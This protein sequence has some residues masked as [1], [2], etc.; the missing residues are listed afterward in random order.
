MTRRVTDRNYTERILS[1]PAPAALHRPPGQCG[2]EVSRTR[3]T[4]VTGQREVGAERSTVKNKGEWLR[5]KAVCGKADASVSLGWAGM[6]WG[7]SRDKDRDRNRSF[8]R[9]IKV[10]SRRGTEAKWSSRFWNN[11]FRL[12]GQAIQA[13]TGW[14]YLINGHLA[15]LPAGRASD[16]GAGVEPKPWLEARPATRLAGAVAGAARTQFTGAGDRAVETRWR[17]G[18][19]G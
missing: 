19:Q 3:C 13:A 15:V 1:A 12:Q 16:L 9:G 5:G 17:F 4:Q 11:A 10:N 18:C 14:A 7:S 2:H 6:D 8:S